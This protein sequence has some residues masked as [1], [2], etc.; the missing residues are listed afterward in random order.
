[1][2]TVTFIANK[3]AVFI[4]SNR[5]EN[6][7]R[8][9]T[10]APAI[11]TINDKKICYPTD[12]K[13]SGT[14]IGINEN[15]VA[16]VLLNGAFKKHISKGNYKRSRGFIIPQIL[17]SS[18]PEKA[19]ESIDFSNIEPFTLILFFENKLI[20]YRWDEDELFSNLLSINQFYIWSSA[21]LYSK[22][23]TEQKEASFMQYFNDSKI[24]SD[25]IIAFHKS[26]KYEDELP[27]DAAKNNIKT[28]SITQ[29]S[30]AATS[31]GIN[32]FDCINNNQ[33][34]TILQTQTS[35]SFV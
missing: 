17:Q 18:N 26:K 30:I 7:F 14:W 28:V 34:N 31:C 21:T 6:I 33:H 29:V 32:Y 4:T 13:A 15:N 9:R 2:C 1:M 24:N 3:D 23:I 22:Q 10:L 25:S 20:E 5:D 8:E 11:Y 27:N 35:L 12:G 19:I 16:A